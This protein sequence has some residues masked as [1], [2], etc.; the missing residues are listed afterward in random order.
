MNATARL[1]FNQQYYELMYSEWLRYRSRYRRFA[2][3]IAIALTATGI[4]LAI[5][6]ACL[7]C[8]IAV[9]VVAAADLLETITHRR[10]WMTKARGSMRSDD[11]ELR[12][13]DSEIIVNTDNSHGTIRYEGFQ[14]VAATPGGVFLIPQ[15][16]ASIFVPL[17]TIE[18]Q[19]VVESLVALL[20]TRIN[21]LR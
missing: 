17:A 16:G 10:R 21:E 19:D 15:K 20:L 3:P 14:S 5:W 1:N 13:T 11:G 7:P 9:V 18:P 4:G 12:F 6:A 8:A 2:V